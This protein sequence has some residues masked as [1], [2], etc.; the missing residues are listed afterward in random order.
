MADLKKIVEE[1]GEDGEKKEG[2]D[3]QHFLV[4]TEMKNGRHEVFIFQISK[5]DPKVIN[6]KI[7]EVFTSWILPLKLTLLWGLFFK[8]LRLVNLDA[9]KPMKTAVVKK[10]EEQVN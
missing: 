9:S 6:E 2:G 3:C 10:L 4:D 1:E 8:I 7:E 5:L